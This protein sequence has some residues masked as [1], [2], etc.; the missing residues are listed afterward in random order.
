MKFTTMRFLQESKVREM[1]Q[2]VLQ[3]VQHELP[4]SVTL[5]QVLDKMMEINGMVHE[6]HYTEEES[7]YMLDFY[8][9]TI[10]ISITS[11]ANV[12]AAE[13]KRLVEEYLTQLS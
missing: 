11:K 3:P 10:G 2:M 1:A 8:T 5:D 9:T 4:S 12:V 7:Q 13:T 6:K